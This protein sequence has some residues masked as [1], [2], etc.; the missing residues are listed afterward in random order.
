M[1]GGK[2]SL[3]IGT[4]KWLEFVEGSRALPTIIDK[5]FRI[6]DL[7]GKKVTGPRKVEEVLK[8]LAGLDI[9]KQPSDFQKL[10]ELISKKV[11]AN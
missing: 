2:N 8:E 7:N 11:L 6:I 3:E 1:T 10:N 4:G 9:K 5:C